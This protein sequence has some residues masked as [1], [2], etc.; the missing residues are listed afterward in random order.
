MSAIAQAP[1]PAPLNRRRRVRQKVHAPAYA[2]FSGA[3][4]RGLVDLNEIVDIREVGVAVQ[5]AS[6]MKVD[7]QVDLCL[8]LWEASGQISANARVVWSDA[9]GRV[10]LALPALTNSALHRLREWLF[11]NAMA[12]AANAAASTPS[13]AATPEPAPP[14]PTITHT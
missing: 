12:G 2:T 11:M 7:Q 9:T 13:P 10:G 3:S 5:C 1:R 8:D 6:P 14:P 4:G